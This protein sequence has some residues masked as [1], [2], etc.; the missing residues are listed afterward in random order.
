[1]KLLL[2]ELSKHPIGGSPTD[3]TMSRK[4]VLV[5]SQRR[6]E[7]FEFNNEFDYD[8]PDLVTSEQAKIL[9]F[10]LKQSS[11]IN[12]LEVR[13]GDIQQEDED[14]LLYIAEALQ[15]NS[16]L[17]ELC[18]S[19]MELRYTEPN[20]SALTK[21]LHM[22]KSLSHLNLSM[23]SELS[24]SGACCIFKGLQYS[25]SLTHLNLMATGIRA[26]D[27][28]TAQS[29][30]K[31][32]QMNKY[33]IYLDLS[34]NSFLKTTA[35]CI[36]KGLQHNTTLTHL[37][38]RSTSL[39]TSNIDTARCLTKMLQVNKSLTHLDLPWNNTITDSGACC[40]FEGL[41]YN[42]NLTHLNL[43]KTG[44]RAKYLNTARSLTKML[45]MNKSL[46]HLHLSYNFFLKSRA[47]R[48]F[49]GLQHNTTLTHLRLKNTALATNNIDTARCLTKML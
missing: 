44:V 10:H 27:L 15:T 17:T 39:A 45:L 21:M 46:T 23:N 49:K 34:S 28:D 41:Q 14:G 20:G 6:S 33:L 3:G 22:N 11:V 30:S 24:D 9:A 16:S 29:L 47:C 1:M 5:L 40:I 8:E 26:T 32:L 37:S 31:M 19:R 12:T 43:M 4:L 48:I 13:N 18:L 36:F 2:S 42:T 38:L 35:C 25:T 7:P